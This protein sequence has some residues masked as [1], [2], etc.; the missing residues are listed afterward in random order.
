MSL[1]TGHLDMGDHPLTVNLGKNNQSFLYKI[2]Q[3]VQAPLNQSTQLRLGAC[4]SRSPPVHLYKGQECT[5]A[6]NQSACVG[7]PRHLWQLPDLLRDDGWKSG[8]LHKI[9]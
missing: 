7:H 8:G 3:N 1:L 6:D 2:I 5:A 4:S 9:K